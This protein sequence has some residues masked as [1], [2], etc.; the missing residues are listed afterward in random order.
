MKIGASF[1]RVIF[2]LV[3][4]AGLVVCLTVLWKDRASPPR[5]FDSQVWKSN[6]ELREQ[7][8]DDFFARYHV[9]QK[10]ENELRNELGPSDPGPDAGK[11]RYYY[12]LGGNRTMRI[13]TEHGLVSDYR[14]LD[15]K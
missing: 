15:G 12:R 5:G 7:M 8:V 2:W 3:L 6:P 9:F 4:L 10:Q 1:R 11:G 13:T 14:I